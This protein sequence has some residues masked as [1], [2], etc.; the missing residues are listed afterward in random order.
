MSEIKNI[1]VRDG[2]IYCNHGSFHIE[3]FYRFLAWMYAKISWPNHID[4]GCC[5]SCCVLSCVLPLLE[6]SIPNNK[7][8]I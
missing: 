5:S 4:R 6:M 1:G 2:C 7:S 3:I 8:Q